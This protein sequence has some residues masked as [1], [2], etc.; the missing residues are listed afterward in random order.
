MPKR[1]SC[2]ERRLTAIRH[3]HPQKS[4]RGRWGWTYEP[5]RPHLRGAICTHTA[6]WAGLTMETLIFQIA[7][8]C[9]G[10]VFLKHGFLNDPYEA[11]SFVAYLT[12]SG[13]HFSQ[14]RISRCEILK[15]WPSSKNGVR[16]Q[17]DFLGRSTSVFCFTVPASVSL[18][19]LLPMLA[20]CAQRL[21]F[22]AFA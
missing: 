14:K 3:C 15:C 20:S 1:K 7:S 18:L 8:R 17:V 6:G 4:Q 9:D 12:K 5:T 2:R 10:F 13:P 21:K 19:L 16:C 22:V 11:C